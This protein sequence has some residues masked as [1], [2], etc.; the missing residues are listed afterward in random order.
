MKKGLWNIPN[1]KDWKPRDVALASAWEMKD[2][3]AQAIINLEL[4]GTYIHRVDGCDTTKETWDQLNTLFG[5]NSKS[6]KFGFND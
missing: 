6:S 1:G 5:P 4:D 2:D 3:K